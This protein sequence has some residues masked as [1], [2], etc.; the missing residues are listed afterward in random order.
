MAVFIG[1]IIFLTMIR[2]FVGTDEFSDIFDD[3]EDNRTW[4][5]L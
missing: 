5:D 2:V 4:R 1:I 3:E